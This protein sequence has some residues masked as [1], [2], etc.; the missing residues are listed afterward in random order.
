MAVYDQVESPQW[1][2]GQYVI[3][4][5]ASSHLSEGLDTASLINVSLPVQ[6]GYLTCEL[7]PQV[8]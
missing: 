1:T 6:R 3:P 5:L 2:F 8:K 7:V 4:T